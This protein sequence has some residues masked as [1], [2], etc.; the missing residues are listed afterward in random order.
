[1]LKTESKYYENTFFFLCVI[2][3]LQLILSRYTS[4][5]V[6]L[7]VQVNKLTVLLLAQ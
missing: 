3:M 5:S 6:T 4:N 7:V 2:R 1:M